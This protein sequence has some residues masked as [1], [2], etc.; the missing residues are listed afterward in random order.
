MTNSESSLLKQKVISNDFEDR[1]VISIA[2]E[3]KDSAC[4]VF[5]IR[6]GKLVGKKQLHLSLRGGE[7]LEEIYTSAIKFYYGDHV[8]IPKEILD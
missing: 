6:G 3:D 8:E 1:D 4:S 5:N 2:F 7:E